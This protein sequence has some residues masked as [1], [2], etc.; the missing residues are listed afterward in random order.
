MMGKVRYKMERDGRNIVV[1][2]VADPDL[3][4]EGVTDCSFSLRFGYLEG[5]HAD[6][7]RTVKFA[8]VTLKRMYGVSE[9][10]LEQ[11]H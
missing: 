9:E 3:L 8:K 4:P 11:I 5:N 6:I 7:D 2:G 1:S 10:Q